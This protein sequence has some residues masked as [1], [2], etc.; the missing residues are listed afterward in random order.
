MVVMKAC[1]TAALAVVSGA[2]LGCNR[3]PAPPP[4]P[5]VANVVTITASDFSFAAPDSIPAGLTTVKLSNTGKEPH[6]V[7]FIRIDSGKTMTDIANVMKDPNA[8]IPA[9]M[10]FP[11]GANTVEPGDSSNAT[12]A[13]TAGNY[14]LICFVSSP[15]GTPHASKGMVRPVVV[16]AATGPMAA[17]PTADITI[18]EKDY[19][20]D[21]SGPITAGMHTFRVENAGPQVHEVQIFQLAPKKTGKDFQ[22]WM[23]GGMKGPPPATEV[24]GFVGPM[25]VAGA[26][27]YF[28]RTLAAGNYL[29]ICFVPDVKDAKPHV[30]HGMIKE[31]TV[32]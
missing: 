21:I 19:T 6:Q 8:K 5:P 17:E 11:M 16:T 3:K 30:M 24:G 22:A 9:W 12:A 2:M 4:A 27:G 10:S 26:H 32:S 25:P 13:L 15:N 31:V 23:T 7:V 20:W 18:T 28:T 29:F 14:V 1:T